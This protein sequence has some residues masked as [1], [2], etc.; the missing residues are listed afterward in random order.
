MKKAKA[1][2]IFLFLLT[3]TANAQTGRNIL[4]EVFTNSHCPLCVGA[5]SALNDYYN[6]SNEK[7]R[8]KLIYYHMVFPY[9][10]DPLNLYNQSD[11]AARN[12]YYGPFGSTPVAFFDGIQQVGNQYTKWPD[13]LNTHLNTQSPIELNLSGAIENGQINL[14]ADIH[15]YS[16]I[17]ENDLVIY[18]VAVED[19]EYSGRNGIS[20]HKNVMRAMYKSSGES[21]SPVLNESVSAGADIT[22]P[23]DWN[24]DK[25]K[26]VSFIQSSSSKN[27]YQSN[28]ISYGELVSTG[29]KNEFAGKP[30][31]KLFQNFPNPFN[32][33]TEINY[34]IP[35]ESFVELRIFNFIGQEIAV[36]VKEIQSEGF[37]RFNFNAGKYGLSSG[38]YFYQ[39]KA[40]NFIRTNKMILSK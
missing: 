16:E 25:L 2:F 22:V 7:N 28:S 20:D 14:K 23:D 12:N 21:I 3:I 36:I 31:Y 26:I 24:T 32:P 1:I 35:E 34:Y 37:Y 11:A 15:S 19:V 5:H 33:T 40:G 10:D 17:N 39:L 6:S 30:D 29:I 9:S 18:F 13:S 27:I 38:V 8:I 4:V